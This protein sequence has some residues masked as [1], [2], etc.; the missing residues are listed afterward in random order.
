MSR[1]CFAHA[2]GDKVEAAR[3]HETHAVRA[4]V[5]AATPCLLSGVKQTS[6]GAFPMSAFDGDF[7]R[8]TQHLLILPGAA[9]GLAHLPRCTQVRHQLLLQYAA[10]LNK[11]SAYD[12]KRKYHRSAVPSVHLRLARSRTRPYAGRA[13]QASNHRVTAAWSD[14]FSRPILPHT[15]MPATLRSATVK[16]LPTK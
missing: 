8:S 14:R 15:R 9:L 13:K 16:L 7:N 4:L 11:T 6:R 3:T 10:C 2:V 5:S 1:G 12:P